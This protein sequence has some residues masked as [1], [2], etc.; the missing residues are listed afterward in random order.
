MVT[1]AVITFPVPDF[2]FANE[3]YHRRQLADVARSLRDGKINTALNVDLETTQSTTLIE[4]SR[5]STTSRIVLTASNPHAAA[6]LASGT[7]EVP[8]D[9]LRSGE[10]TIRHTISALTRSFRIVILA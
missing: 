2:D 8:G 7:V 9:L 10:A 5:I 3:R 4:D 6:D 1:R